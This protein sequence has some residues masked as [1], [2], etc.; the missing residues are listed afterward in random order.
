MATPDEPRTGLRF[1]LIGAGDIGRLRAAAIGAARAHRLTVVSDV[2]GQRAAQV[3]SPHGAAHLDDWRSVLER[4]DVDAVIISTPPA[5]HA[6]MCMRAL[7]AGKHVLC[8]KP[9]ARTPEECRI[10]VNAAAAAERVLA[11]GFNYRFYPSFM[12]AREYLASGAIGDLSHIRSYGGY[13]ATGH[14]QP[15]VHDAEV[16]GGGAL[17]DIGIHLIDLTRSFLG[18][19]SAVV[20]FDSGSVWNYPGCEDNGFLM[21]RSPKGVVATLHASWTEWGRYQFLIELV[22]TRGTIR[23]SCFPMRLELLHSAATGGRVRRRVHRFP[24]VMLGEH[25]R[26]YRWVVTRSFIAEFDAFAALVRGDASLIANGTDGL[27][28]LEIARGIAPHDPKSASAWSE[29]AQPAG[30][31]RP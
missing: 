6:E 20:R 15:W 13:S 25:L 3:A 23:V 22:G 21:M 26:S 11:T 10:M 18:D 31:S 12:L 27:R 24:G 16:V 28:A 2:D 8:E 7:E 5:L 1:G 17:H 30:A 9:L 19:V 14:N 29:R 4:D